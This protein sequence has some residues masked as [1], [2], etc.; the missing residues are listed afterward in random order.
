MPDTD[1]A[2]FPN[3]YRA[4]TRKS[5]YNAATRKVSHAA[6]ILRT[7]EA[8]LSV[9]KAVGCSRDICLASQRDCFGEFV[10]ETT[11]VRNLGL[12]VVDDRPNAPDFSEN[13]A[14]ITNIPTSPVT[15]EEKKLAEHLAY[16]LA[17]ISILH[18]DLYD[19]D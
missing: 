2:Q 3:I 19:K 18:H 5:W 1:P 7:Q 4:I 12:R 11:R 13:H 8:G 6:F 15:F 10:L 9:L 14:E 17:E 16:D